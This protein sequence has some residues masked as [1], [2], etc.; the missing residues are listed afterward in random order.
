MILSTRS[1]WVP[2]FS[3]SRTPQTTFSLLLVKLEFLRAERRVRPSPPRSGIGFPPTSAGAPASW[4]TLG[5][6]R[7]KRSR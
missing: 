2:F 7:Q 5:C 1:E 6:R 3:R 4:R